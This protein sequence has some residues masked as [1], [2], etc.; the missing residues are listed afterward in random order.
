MGKEFSR[1][2]A[3][4]QGNERRETALQC[5]P[6]RDLRDLWL[7]KEVYLHPA[8]RPASLPL[9]GLASHPVLY[10]GQIL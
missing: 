6:A 4:M 10:S 2:K 5:L 1:K 9:G 3:F 7:E 8:S